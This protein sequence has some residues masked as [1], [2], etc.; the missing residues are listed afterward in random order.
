M[1]QSWYLGDRAF[2]NVDPDSVAHMRETSVQYQTNDPKREFVERVIE[3]HL[4]PATEIGFDEI[5]YRRSDREVAMPRTFESHEDVLNGFRALTAPGT[6]FIRHVTG[7][8]VNLLYVRL[9]NYRGVDRYFTIV[10]N[11]WHDKNQWFGPKQPK[12]SAF[13]EEETAEGTR[14]GIDPRHD[15]NRPPA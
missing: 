8:D 7:T 9:R 6:G 14:Q 3:E 1:M 5:N 10:I 11:R 2:E 12:L 13:A 4:L 15:R